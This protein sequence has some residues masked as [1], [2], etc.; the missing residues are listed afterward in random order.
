[1]ET[2]ARKMSS[3]QDPALVREAVLNFPVIEHW[4]WTKA[5]LHLGEEH[6]EQMSSLPLIDRLVELGEIGYRVEPEWATPGTVR[7]VLVKEGPGGSRETVSSLHID[8][9]RRP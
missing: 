5:R 1:M 6:A 9:G 2:T 7:Y 8:K 3:M 4:F